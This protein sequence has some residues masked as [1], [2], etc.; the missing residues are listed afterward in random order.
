VEK[1]GESVVRYVNRQFQQFDKDGND[2]LDSSE[3]SPSKVS[4]TAEQIDTDKDGQVSKREL[5][6][7][8]VARFR[9]RRGPRTSDSSTSGQPT[10]N[11]NSPSSADKGQDKVHRYA[12]GLLR[13][14]DKNK[15][16]V[17]E[18][19]EWGRLRGDPKGY[20]RNG[21][22]VLNVD[23]LAAKLSEFSNTP[24]SS[25]AARDTRAAAARPTADEPLSPEAR[26]NQYK[27]RTSQNSATASANRKSYR[28]LSP[29]ERLPSGLPQW[30]VE[31]DV[32]GD[33]Q[34]AMAEF[35][36]AWTDAK[37]GEFVR[38]DLNKDGVLTPAE[39]LQSLRK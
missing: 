5:C 30:F 34:I 28:A 1:Y 12:S 23:E 13:R 10:M 24:D 27:A 11:P 3:W 19:D 16:G 14:Y 36:T 7:I 4:A 22:G 17:L 32:N 39:V 2:L 38:H 21:D 29:H 37:A 9:E 33:G 31:K 25:S 20:D 8:M 35:E 15:S 6:E 18:P 26:W